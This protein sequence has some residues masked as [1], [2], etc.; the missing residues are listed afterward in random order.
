MESAAGDAEEVDHGVDLEPLP[1]FAQIDSAFSVH[2]VAIFRSIIKHYPRLELTSE[3]EA[4]WH[5]FLNAPRDSLLTVR[6]AIRRRESVPHLPK[7]AKP[8]AVDNLTEEE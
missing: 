5:K 1:P 6:K 8:E 7:N 4:V 3:K 2:V